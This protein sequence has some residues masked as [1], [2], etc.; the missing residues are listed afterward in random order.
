MQ[1]RNQ[2]ESINDAPTTQYAGDERTHTQTNAKGR[3]KPVGQINV[4]AHTLMLLPR[5]TGGEM[6]QYA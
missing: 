5:R 2:Q 4:T 3:R 1:R 6:N